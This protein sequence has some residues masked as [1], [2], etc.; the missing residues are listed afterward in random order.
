MKIKIIGAGGVGGY[1]GG[2]LLNSGCDVTFITRGEHLKAINENGLTIKS[3]LGD[4][5]IETVK[6]TDDYK[7]LEDA[8]LV[9]PGVKAWQLREIGEHLKRYLSPGAIVLPL[10]NGVLA[11]NELAEYIPGEQIVG[12]LCKIISKIES[13]GVINHFGVEPSIVIGE[14]DKSVSRRVIEISEILKKSGIDAAY[15]EDIDAALWTK[16]IAICVSALLGITRS[17][18]GVVRELKET[19]S[20][21][22]SLLEEI[23]QVAVAEQI[24]LPA[25]IVDKTVAFIESFPYDATSSLTRDIWECKPSEIEYQN[26]TVVKLGRKHGIATPVNEFIYS[27]ILPQEIRARKQSS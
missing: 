11:A 21:M 17:T 7:V 16:F 18:Y 5:E 8:D 22:I 12:G 26:G 1:F 4:F 15:T 9:I 2:K 20:L 14:F 24:N 6:A 10:Q 3:I 19:R 23:K 13:P 27:C 25:D